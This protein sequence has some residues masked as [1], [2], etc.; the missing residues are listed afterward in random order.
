[1]KKAENLFPGI[2]TDPR[3]TTSDADGH[4][5]IPSGRIF[6]SRNASDAAPQ[7]LEE[8]QLHFFLPRRFEDSLGSHAFVDYTH[9]LLL[10]GTE[11]AVENKVIANNDYRVL[12]P[13][14]IIDPNGNRAAAV[15]DALGL[16]AGT[17]VMSKAT[18][19]V[20][21]SL[22]A[23]EADLTVQQINDF[24]EVNDPHVPAPGLL[25]NATTCIVYDL[26][27][28]RKSQ[29]ANPT[30]PTKWEPVF[31][32][33]LARET[34][35]S[36][37]LPPDGL[38][39]QISFSYFDG[40]GREIQKKIQGEPGPV[41]EDG[42][43][44]DPRWVGS[45]WTIFNNKGKP[46][47]EYEPFFDDTHDFKFGK[48]IGVSPILFYDPVERVV[49]T[50]HP[51]H[52]W[53]KIVFDPWKQETWDVNDTVL[54]D[55]PKTDPDVG[56]FFQRLP[57][58]EYLPTWHTQR[59]TSNFG[60]TPEQQLAEQDAA[61][62]ATVH[63]ATPAVAFFDT[64]GRA[65]LTIAHNRKEAAGADEFYATRI[66]LDIEG[67]QREVID[68]KDRIV[69]RY[70]YE[71][72]GNRIHQASMDAGERWILND[73][74]GKPIRAWDSRGHNFKTEYDS[75]RRPV[76]RFVRGTDSTRSDP[77]TLG[78]DVLFG[79]IEYGEGQ[80]NDVALNLRTRAFKSYDGAGVVTNRGNNPVTGEDEGYDF[81]ATCCGVLNNS[82]RTTKR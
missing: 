7:E 28:F 49:G 51:N 40:F 16:V 25:S 70:D 37:L 62:K 59:I 53:E 45:G 54:I 23:F 77:R 72:L 63:A 52:T 78:A 73:V 38:K 76:H 11:D 64:L 9:D 42:P 26:D 43:I 68:A 46:V 66:E 58:A 29:E 14:L 8:A 31:A 60:D 18:E 5:W 47:R 32:A 35:A 24:F 27:R 30:D 67:N 19:N 1:M 22:A 34:H 79:K 82:R 69:M 74:T 57:D 41:E 65:F 81:K 17:A 71:M 10:A 20:G 61:Q 75:L 36:D 3:W 50:L 6:Y 39:I 56:T 44:V 15:F 4:W 80:A 33:T 48:Q 2:S 12:Q 13:R 21:D 55:D